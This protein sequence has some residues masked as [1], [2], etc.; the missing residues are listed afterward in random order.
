MSSDK[1][2]TDI[3]P[4]IGAV[5]SSART[6]LM[7]EHSLFK[8]LNLEPLLIGKGKATF[9]VDLPEAFSDNAGYIHGGLYT[10][11]M[12][13]IFGMTVFTALEKV[14]PIATINLRSDYLQKVEPGTRAVCAAECTEIV[15]NIAYVYGD[16]QSK[17]SGQ[18]LA[19]GSGTFMVGTRSAAK[20]SRI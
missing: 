4:D 6:F 9:A 10:T 20:G 16:L 3:N 11:I 1:V 13:S 14:Q 19:F 18:R 5:L 2:S 7:H 8:S 17:T 12:D 15:N